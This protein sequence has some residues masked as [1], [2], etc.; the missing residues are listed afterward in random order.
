MVVYYTFILYSTLIEA[1]FSLETLLAYVPYFK[2]G[3]DNSIWEN[4]LIYH[5]RKYVIYSNCIV[6]TV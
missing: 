4:V 5:V 1:I 2:T 3:K 6:L